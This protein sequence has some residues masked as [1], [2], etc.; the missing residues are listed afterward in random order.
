MELNAGGTIVEETT[1]EDGNGGEAADDGEEGDD[2]DD[3]GA[4]D[5][6]TTSHE[7]L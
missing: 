7:C 4:G 5:G 1:D 3:D 2:G 6:E